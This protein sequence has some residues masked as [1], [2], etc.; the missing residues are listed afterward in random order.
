MYKIRTYNQIAVRGLERFPRDRYEVSS[1]ISDPHAVLLRSHQLEGT[2]LSKGLRA[3]ARAGAGFNNVP[4]ADCTERGIV[5]FNTPG[6]NANSVKELVIAALLLSA[7]DIVGG[8]QFV[9]GLKG[10]DDEAE[11]DRL[12]EAEK[13]LAVIL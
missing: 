5:V 9:R 11:L 2:Q 4:V 10:I 12:V 6:A 1:E 13:N 3:V 7:R 8:I